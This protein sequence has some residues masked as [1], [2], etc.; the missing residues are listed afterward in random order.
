MGF[1]YGIQTSSRPQL[2]VIIVNINL[3][4]CKFIKYNYNNTFKTTEKLIKT[5]NIKLFY[6]QYFLECNMNFTYSNFRKAVDHMDSELL[7]LLDLHM[8]FDHPPKFREHHRIRRKWA[9]HKI[10]QMVS[11]LCCNY[12]MLIRYMKFPNSITFNDLL[13]A[14]SIS[15]LNT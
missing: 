15:P 1:G 3:K 4:L 6:N 2:F 7:N 11:F 9:Y 12:T 5:K 13:I 8:N 14:I 10:S